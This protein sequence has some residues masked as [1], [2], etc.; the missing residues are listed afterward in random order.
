MSNG[1]GK[2]GANNGNVFQQA[3]TA[4]N[5]AGGATSAAFDAFSSLGG[6]KPALAGD[7]SGYR[8]STVKT[9]AQIAAGIDTYMN[10]YTSN[11]IDTTLSTLDRARLMAQQS[12][13]DAAIAAG[14]FGGS[15]HGIV[16]AETNAGFARQAA[17]TAAGLRQAGF[18]T[19]AELASRD[20]D[21]R[22]AAD[23]FNATARNTSRAFGASA[24][25]QFALADQI[26]RNQAAQFGGQQRAIGAQG[27]LGAGGQAGALAGQ[28]V[29]IGQSINNQ[30]A[31]FGS[32]QQSAMQAIIDAARSNFSGYT[33]Q[34]TQLLSLLTGVLAGSPL[35]N[36]TTTTQSY[37]PGL[38]DWLS[39]AA[40]TA[41]SIYNPA[42]A[43]GSAG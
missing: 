12:N 27:M 14:A 38:L 5:A 22:F 4:Y 37:N 35:N 39:L 2:G 13:G 3:A 7:A 41:G 33:G 30:N 25:N 19:A 23:T 36:Q 16:E 34:G 26:A 18:N 20:I 17:E 6:Y 21:N 11:V 24:D 29:Q 28:G 32:Q 31:G 9:P 1:G 43:A 42:G 10:P 15:R 8:A 40:Q